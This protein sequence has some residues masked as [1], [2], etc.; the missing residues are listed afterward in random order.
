MGS[1]KAVALEDVTDEGGMIEVYVGNGQTAMVPSGG[2][3]IIIDDAG[4]T[5]KTSRPT[6]DSPIR[7]EGYVNRKEVISSLNISISNALK[8]NKINLAVAERRVTK[9]LT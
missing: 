2:V 4:T 7:R 1:Q 9:K 3:T 5:V 6:S 8:N